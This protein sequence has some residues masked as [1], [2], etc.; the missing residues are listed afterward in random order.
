MSYGKKSWREWVLDE[1]EGIEQIK[2]AYA[3]GI[4]VSISLFYS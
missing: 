2:A 3:A 4:N 1:Q